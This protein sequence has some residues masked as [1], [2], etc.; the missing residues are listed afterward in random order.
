M[1]YYQLIILL[2]VLWWK[3]HSQPSMINYMKTE[4]DI[5]T[6]LNTA[7]FNDAYIYSDSKGRPVGIAAKVNRLTQSVENPAII[8]VMTPEDKHH[9]DDCFARCVIT[10]LNF[11]QSRY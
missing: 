8:P 9:F 7:S 1:I 6:R 2:I 5:S 11:I 10:A 3:Y 4:T